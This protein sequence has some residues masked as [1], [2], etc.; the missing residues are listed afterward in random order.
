MAAA[1]LVALILAAA[2]GQFDL[3]CSG[4]ETVQ[5]PD[6]AQTS[7]PY[8]KTWVIDLD[9]G[10]FC[11]RGCH[12]AGAIAHVDPAEIVLDDEPG[13]VRILVKVNRSTGE[14]FSVM[15]APERKSSVSATC[16]LSPFTGLPA[17]AF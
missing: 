10:T 7:R 2:S 13:P 12:A 9:A 15:D 16:K 6:G 3:D 14:L 4:M 17:R 11:G 1:A 5:G 8:A